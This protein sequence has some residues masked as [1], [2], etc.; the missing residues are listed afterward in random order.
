MHAKIRRLGRAI[1]TSL[2]GDRKRRVETAGQEVETLLGEDPPNPKEV[3]IRLKGWYKAA[4]N[5]APPP[6]RSTLK[7]IMTERVDLYSYV[8]SPGE[9]ILVTV[10]PA[11]VDDSV[12]TEDEIK[13]AVKK[14]RRNRSGG[15]SGMRAEHLK[16][17]LAASNR[18][19]RAV[20]ESPREGGLEC[21]RRFGD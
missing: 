2:Q 12:P 4:V 17:W 11:E 13:D 15:P 16:G 6:A 19:K 8:P 21:T 7:R 3:W 14:L 9:N 10:A 5:R 1:R 18:E 20:G